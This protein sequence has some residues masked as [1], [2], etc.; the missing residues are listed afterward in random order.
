MHAR[1][2]IHSLLHI[3]CAGLGEVSEMALFFDGASDGDNPLDD[4]VSRA[5]N[6]VA[7]LLAQFSNTDVQEEKD[8][9]DGLKAAVRA[10]TRTPPPK[11]T[12]RPVSPASAS[13]MSD[14]NASLSDGIELDQFMD[15][16]EAAHRGELVEGHV[17]EGVVAS[18]YDEKVH[19]TTSSNNLNVERM[20]IKL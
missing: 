13:S 17:A 6:E 16:I 1:A 10:T 18:V 15:D 5:E 19:S 2:H 20:R 11:G 12:F 9:R 4:S 14:I 8:V 3:I 7:S